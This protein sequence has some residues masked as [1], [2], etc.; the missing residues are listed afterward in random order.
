MRDSG[1]AGLGDKAGAGSSAAAAMS[2]ASVR[3]RSMVVVT[4]MPGL[5]L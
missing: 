4:Q 2:W 1:R 3:R 5:Q